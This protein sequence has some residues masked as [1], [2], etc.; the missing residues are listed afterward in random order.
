M[1]TTS[2]LQRSVYA[3]VCVFAV[4]ASTFLASFT[5]EDAYI[6]ARYAVNA[7]DLGEWVFNR[8]EHVSALTSPLHGLLLI[9]LSWV[10]SD[11]IPVYKAI[12]AAAVV[13]S[14]ALMLA[15]FGLERREAMPLAA[16]AVAPN[17]IL[18]TF[19]GL[20]TPL[21]AA[22]VTAMAALYSRET[23]RGRGW[24][25]G[26]AAL[27]GL[28]VVTRYDAVLF[29]GPVVIAALLQARCGGRERLLSVLAAT[30]VPAAW[31]VYS[32]LAF[33]SVLPTSFYVK[34]PTSAFDVVQL[35]MRYMFE[36]LLISGV[37]VMAMFA[38]IA[39]AV[40]GA[41]RAT[42]M[43]ELRARVGLHAGL[44]VVLVYGLTM[45]TVHM[46]FAFRHFAPYLASTALALAHLARPLHDQDAPRASS[47][48]W[49]TAAAAAALILI[50]P[51]CAGRRAVSPIS[52]GSRHAWRIRATG[53]GGVYATLYSGY[54]EKRGGHQGALVPAR[55]EPAAAHMD[56]CRRL[57]AVLLPRRVHT[58]RTRV[59]PQAVSAPT[60]GQPARCPHLAGARRLHPRVHTPRQSAASL[61]AG[62]CASAD[63]DFRAADL[64][65]T[66][67]TR[68]SSSTTILHPCRMCC[69]RDR[70]PL[71]GSGQGNVVG[72]RCS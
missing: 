48:L 61:G 71:H 72:G 60:E 7:R 42:V 63:T 53:R 27:G 15:G 2:L 62:V 41:P 1:G 10:A 52:A 65:S 69:R 22:I 46:M 17:M 54:G 14:C 44:A 64:I 30:L 70:R 23:G 68:S 49:Y 56:V 38:L 33:G 40:S 37:G 55:R 45:A 13:G 36:Q 6:V 59:I 32:W 57:F 20:E 8:G 66:A 67:A 58:R 31:L 28:A 39:L 19:G 12:G 25:T 29:A 26:V 21:L 47:R 9:V 18:W 51:C 43:R 5:A 24:L 50:G 11:P 4:V 34:T 3:A 16:A 35:N